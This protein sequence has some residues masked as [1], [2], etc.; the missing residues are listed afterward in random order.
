MYLYGSQKIA[1]ENKPVALYEHWL[2]ASNKPINAHLLDRVFVS[3]CVEPL[4]IVCCGFGLTYQLIQLDWGGHVLVSP[5][6]L[7]YGVVNNVRGDYPASAY[8]PDDVIAVFHDSII[9]MDR[10]KRNLS[11]PRSDYYGYRLLAE[12]SRYLLLTIKKGSVLI[13][14]GSA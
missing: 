2:R 8:K 1:T 7:I 12:T 9:R 11:G 6:T 10:V 14:P 3:T 13:R 4:D 5:D